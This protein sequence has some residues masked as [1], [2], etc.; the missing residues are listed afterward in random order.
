MSGDD[1]GKNVELNVAGRAAFAAGILAGW[2]TGLVG[3]VL[4]KTADVAISAEQAFRE[5]YCSTVAVEEAK[6]LQE[7]EDPPASR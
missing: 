4:K 3:S 2:T 7:Q 1:T 5:G 6:I